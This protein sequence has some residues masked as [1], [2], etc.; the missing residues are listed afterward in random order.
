[1][2][3][4]SVNA[5]AEALML[6]LPPPVISVPRAPWS[7]TSIVPVLAYTSTETHINNNNKI[8]MIIIISREN[9]PNLKV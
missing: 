1:M 2:T 4:P 9:I 3:Q 5:L 8:I 7:Q 6:A